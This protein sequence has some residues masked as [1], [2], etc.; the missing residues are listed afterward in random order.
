M[1][2]WREQLNPEPAPQEPD[3]PRLRK[4]AFEPRT[5]SR[6]AAAVRDHILRV[7]EIDPEPDQELKRTINYSTRQLARAWQPRGPHAALYDADT[8]QTI[9]QSIAQ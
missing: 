8:I 7:Y 9:R 6:A 1:A 5:K 4:E 2:N 3:H